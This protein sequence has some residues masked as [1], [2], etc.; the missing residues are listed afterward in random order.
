MLTVIANSLTFELEVGDSVSFGRGGPADGVELQ[1]SDDER[2]HRRAGRATMTESGCELANTGGWLHLLV[3]SLDGPGRDDLGPGETRLIPW[4]RV[5]IDIPLGDAE[6]GFEVLR[7]GEPA[8][9]VPGDEVA[10]EGQYTVQALRVN[11]SAGYFRALVALCE[12]RL[13]DPATDE[14][15]SDAQIALRLNSLDLEDRH[16]T[17]KA[18]ER[19]L[20][21]LREALGMKDQ[22]EGTGGGGLERR[23]ARQ[24][25]ADV[26][27]AT[28]TVK[29]SDLHLLAGDDRP[30]TAR[31]AAP[32]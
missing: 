32:R 9:T 18:I 27:L 22:P 15:P 7:H 14:L 11:R 23:D 31:Q 17:A 16:V 25:L 8:A 13:L 20:N 29:R 2:L 3:T 21:Y 4:R 10:T 24:R 12:Q 6:V 5:R 30:P 26:A 28:G 1:L 19:R